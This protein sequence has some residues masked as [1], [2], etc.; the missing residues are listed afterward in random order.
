MCVEHFFKKMDKISKIAIVVLCATQDCRSVCLWC[1]R[2]Y[3]LPDYIIFDTILLYRMLQSGSFRHMLHPIWVPSER[4]AHGT[5]LE[6]A[7]MAIAVHHA[8]FY[9]KMDEARIETTHCVT[10][11]NNPEA[12]QALC[13]EH[14]SASMH[15]ISTKPPK[16]ILK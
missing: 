13:P 2:I 16:Y 11:C 5:Q 9:V 14:I 7:V 4:S 15:F 1:D 12:S 10:F 8:R 3:Y 6:I